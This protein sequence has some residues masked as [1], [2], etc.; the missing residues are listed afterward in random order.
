MIFYELSALS[1]NEVND[2]SECSLLG[3][4]ITNVIVPS[5]N[6]ILLFVILNVYLALSN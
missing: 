5:S 2:F 6:N 1:F 3:M 4:F